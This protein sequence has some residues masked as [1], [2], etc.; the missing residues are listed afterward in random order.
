MSE[1]IQSSDNLDNLV[2]L[3]GLEIECYRINDKGWDITPASSRRGWMDETRGHA[4]KC[5]PLLAASQM[6]WVIHSPTDFSVIWNGEPSIPATKI[7]IEDKEFE[8]GIISHFGHGIFTFQL[9]YLFR[10]SKEIGLFVRGASNFWVENAIALDGFVET[11]W[12]NYSFTMNWKMVAPHKVATF[13]KGDPI[14][15]LIP[16]P[17][18]LL[19]NVKLAYKPFQEAPAKMQSIFNG[20]HKHRASFNANPN[21]KSGDWQKDYFHGKK[22]PFSGMGEENIGDPHRTKFNLPRFEE[23]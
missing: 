10:T 6:G 4:L 20:W 22:C 3:E 12:S 9:P 2:P 18:R 15:M 7:I 16:Y 14:C 11:N 19:E 8:H 23:S 5:L 1:D 17:I 13:K 21:R